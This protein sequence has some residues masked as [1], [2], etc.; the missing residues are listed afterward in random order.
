[1]AARYGGNAAGVALPHGLTGSDPMSP[2][3]RLLPTPT[4]AL[5]N[6]A[7]TVEAVPDDQQLTE[8]LE[9]SPWCIPLFVV[10]FVAAFPPYRGG[11][12]RD[13]GSRRGALACHRAGSRIRNVAVELVICTCLPT[14]R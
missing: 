2:S 12:V 14:L 1:M 6:T 3:S 4:M 8:H 11:G 13:R 5:L 9:V 10:A 7:A